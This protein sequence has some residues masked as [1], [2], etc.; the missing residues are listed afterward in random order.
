MICVLGWS[1]SETLEQADTGCFKHNFEANKLQ[2]RFNRIIGLQ[3]IKPALIKQH[4][5]YWK[6]NALIQYYTLITP[7]G[8]AATI[9]LLFFCNVRVIVFVIHSSSSSKDEERAKEVLVCS[10][11]SNPKKFTPKPTSHNSLWSH[12]WLYITLFRY[13]VA[14]TKMICL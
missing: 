8:V 6:S 5:W 11:I 7:S 10:H 14:L 13:A 1:L 9:L 2:A 12:K 4:F 3:K